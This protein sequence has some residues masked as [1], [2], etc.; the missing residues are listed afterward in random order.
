MG[1]DLTGTE[2][3]IIRA[4]LAY[5]DVVDSYHLRSVG[6]AHSTFYLLKR[7]A[8][9]EGWIRRTRLPCL[10][11]S[12]VDQVEVSVVHPFADAYSS[13]SRAESARAGTVLL[14]GFPTTLLRVSFT[15]T[16]DVAES[17]GSATSLTRNGFSGKPNDEVL[18]QTHV[19]IGPVA[20]RIGAY[21]D[22]EGAWSRW[23]LD[24]APLVYPRGLDVNAVEEP[25]ILRARPGQPQPVYRTFPDLRLVSRVAGKAIAQVALV[26][27]EAIKGT[28]TSDLISTLA[29]EC[30]SHPFLYAFDE[31]AAILGLLSPRDPST[32]RKRCATSTFPVITKY[33]RKISVVREAV[34]LLR[35]MIDHQYDRFT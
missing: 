18:H 13:V 16:K 35:P 3:R 4:L 9:T 1:R 8:L 20:G 6:V 10:S 5:G 14:W 30:D 7:K 23:A 25:T 12:G 19:R 32:R 29:T 33:L 17:G 21:F 28:R 34:S 27:G 26:C 31:S 15:R 24:E 22:F 2:A 11:Q